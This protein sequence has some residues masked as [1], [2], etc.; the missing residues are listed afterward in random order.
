MVSNPVIQFFCYEQLKLARL[1]ATNAHKA[2][3]GE[4]TLRSVLPPIEA[5]FAGALAKGVATVT[6]YPL[7]LTQTVLRLDPQYKGTLDCLV[8]IY[9]RGGYKELFTGM[10]AKLLQTVLTAAFTFL[11]YEQ[12]L[13]AVQ[14]AL[15]RSSGGSSLPVT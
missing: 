3:L 7:Q 15:L 10:R 1:A 2:A 9:K 4:D 8:Q 11:T 5:F 14:L 12:I 13:G 6:T